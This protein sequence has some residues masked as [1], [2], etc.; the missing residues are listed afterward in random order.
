MLQYG[1]AVR[2]PGAVQRDAPV[3]AE[4]LFKEYSVQPGVTTATVVAA[5]LHHDEPA[6]GCGTQ[7]PSTAPGAAAAHPAKPV[8]AGAP[9]TVSQPAQKSFPRPVRGKRLY[10]AGCR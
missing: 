2:L 6:A 1:I 4:D 8:T 9:A 5:A 10:W 3:L 7:S